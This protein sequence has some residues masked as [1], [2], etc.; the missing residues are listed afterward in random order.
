MA[1]GDFNAILSPSE[2][3][4][5]C[6]NGRRFPFFGD[7]MESAELN[8]VGF[9]GSPFMWYKGGVFERLDRAMGNDVW[10]ASF[11]NC[12]VTH[13]PRLKYFLLGFV[14]ALLRDG[15]F[16]FLVGWIE[17]PEFAKFV[18]DRWSFNGSLLS[19]FLIL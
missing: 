11:P 1:I 10:V 5:G 7:F 9:R 4:G 17:H 19:H 3:K 14:F 15:P 13:L 18:Q 2:K 6:S 8:D 16:A 12:A